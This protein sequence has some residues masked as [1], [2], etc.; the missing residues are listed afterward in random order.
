M[1]TFSVAE[2]SV[3]YT[4]T[5]T[6]PGLVLVH[7][8]SIDA[9]ANFG[10]VIGRFADQRLVIA[11]NY[12]GCGDSTIPEGDLTLDTL[13]EQIAGTIRHAGIGAVDLVGDSLGAVVAAATAATHPSLVRRLVLVSGWADSGDARHQMVFDTWARLEGTDSEL[14][15]RYVMSLAVKPAFLT[16][17]G[18]D[19]IAA[20]LRQAAP[21]D[22][23]RRIALGQRINL[24][25]KLPNISAPTLIVHG[26]HDYLIPAYQAQVL[27]Q[28]IGNSR[29][30]EI[31]S[32]HAVFLEA[33]DEL[34][35]RIR[36][37]LL[38]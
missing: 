35:A 15:N 28:L 3:N 8:T 4:T 13:V 33:A 34:V 5:G 14:S 26:S 1:A 22:T 36:D 6:G 11:P 9:Q 29:Y 37:F 17:L 12:A 25:D 38:D 16:A 23:Q 30:D 32:G 21:P 20:F 10:H 19:N 7:G 2:T 24:R 27:H 18:G 31:D